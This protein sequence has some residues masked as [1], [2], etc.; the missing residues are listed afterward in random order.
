MCIDASKIFTI[1]CGQ[2][3]L[4]KMDGKWKQKM[5]THFLSRIVL[6]KINMILHF[7]SFS[8]FYRTQTVV[9]KIREIS[10]DPTYQLL[11]SLVVVLHVYKSFIPNK[12]VFAK[13]CLTQWISKLSRSFEVHWVR[14]YQV[15]FMCL[16]GIVC[17]TVYKT[18]PNFTGLEHGKLSWFLTL[19]NTP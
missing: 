4:M 17:A 19:N 3:K 9:I 5:Q 15:N 12:T 11:L 1:M 6:M 13:Y 8:R 2:I 16:V 10:I 18:K 7:A 14:Q